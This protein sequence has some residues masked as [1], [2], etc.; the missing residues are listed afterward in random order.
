MMW[1]RKVSAKWYVIRTQPSSEY[2]AAGELQRDG[3]E[4][5]L[6]CISVALPRPGRTDAPLFPGYLFLRCNPEEGG[7]P[8]FRL[9]RKV[10]GWVRFGD[11]VP[12]IPDEFIEELKQSLS[13][14]K[15]SGSMWHRYK[16]GDQVRV[17]SGKIEGLAEVLEG[18][19]SPQS[20]VSVLLQFMGGQVKAQI[21][22]GDIRP[23]EPG[24]RETE[25]RQRRTRGRGRWIN[26][27]GAAARA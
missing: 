8:T 27:H 5:Y 10:Y 21:P 23:M 6:P 15:S 12:S 13:N 16:K 2:L 4:V 26:G 20:R 24:N 11:N 9:G 17:M 22:W 1:R 3:I 7:W 18:S 14:M 25:L 19:A